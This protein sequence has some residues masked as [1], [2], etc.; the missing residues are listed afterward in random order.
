[1]SLLKDIANLI[2][3]RIFKNKNDGSMSIDMDDSKLEARDINNHSNNTEITQNFFVNTEPPA[4]SQPS[5]YAVRNK[6][7]QQK[8]SIGL[9]TGSTLY[10]AI[11]IAIISHGEYNIFKLPLSVMYTVLIP[12]LILP[13]LF[14][15]KAIQFAQKAYD[16]IASKNRINE[17]LNIIFA[18]SSYQIKSIIGLSL[19]ALVENPVKVTPS[20]RC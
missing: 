5:S 6:Q 7:L 11:F 18:S 3:D 16:V 1:M 14:Y 15:G 4:P 2:I 17:F 20:I 8:L 19:L 9:L 12:S 10:S 13:F